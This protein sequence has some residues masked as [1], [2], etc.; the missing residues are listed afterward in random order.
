MLWASVRINWQLANPIAQSSTPIGCA[1]DE[2]A[3][4]TD[5]T[6]TYLTLAGHQQLAAAYALGRLTPATTLES[7]LLA[8]SCLRADET[9]TQTGNSGL[10]ACSP[11]IQSG[12]ADPA[13][14]EVW[15]A[16]TCREGHIASAPLSSIY[17]AHDVQ[18][19]NWFSSAALDEWLARQTVD[20]ASAV[21]FIR[22]YIASA[23][24]VTQQ[25]LA[26]MAYLKHCSE[27]EEIWY[28]QA[29]ISE[30]GGERAEAQTDYQ[31]AAYP[32]AHQET[33]VAWI[34]FLARAGKCDTAQ[35]EAQQFWQYWPN[36]RNSLFTSVAYRACAGQST[37]A[38]I[39][40]EF[41]A[42]YEAETM[43]SGPPAPSLID[44]APVPDAAASGGQARQG[45]LYSGWLVAGPWVSLPYGRYIVTYFV[46]TPPG[47]TD[48]PSVWLDV[49]VTG[50]DWRAEH[51]AQIL[52]GAEATGLSYRSY[53][54]PFTH[55]G[56]GLLEFRVRALTLTPVW[57]DKVQIQDVSCQ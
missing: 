33:V 51:T 6:G 14:I 37:L 21:T 10:C 16:Q 44:A 42:V 20:C 25:R 49:I 36:A 1:W 30:L 17:L 28:Y 29:Q 41:S 26:T 13:S 11:R 4:Q 48:Q 8:L 34:D 56:E 50:A 19:L 27:T 40:Q 24:I 12:R 18:E 47:A 45:N 31:R 5:S 7:E 55:L 3:C 32:P 15:L 52:S 57:V 9:Q 38:S 43:F 39:C 23:G 46:R 35:R 53:T 2:A 54:I 22:D